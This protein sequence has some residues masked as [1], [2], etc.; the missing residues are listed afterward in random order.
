MWNNIPLFI[1]Q[2]G[3]KI[4]SHIINQIMITNQIQGQLR[5]STLTIE[6]TAMNN[7]GIYVCRTTDKT[8]AEVAVRILNGKT[9]PDRY[10]FSAAYDQ[11]QPT[12]SWEGSNQI[13]NGTWSGITLKHCD[14]TVQEYFY[15]NPSKMLNNIQY[16]MN[17]D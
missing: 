8:N 13:L 14:K 2:D 10:G 4:D 3:N 7:A 11:T 6:R 5:I 9:T 16:V 12:A 17:W 1:W 15:I